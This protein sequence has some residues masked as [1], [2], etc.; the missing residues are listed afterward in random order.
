[1]T[2]PDF[3][4]FQ[5][6]PTGEEITMH[7]PDGLTPQQVQISEG[8]RLLG[9]DEILPRD[10]GPELSGIEAWCASDG[11]W[12]NNFGAGYCGHEPNFTYRTHLS[13]AELRAARGLEPEQS[14]QD[15]LKHEQEVQNDLLGT[16]TPRTDV[17]TQP[18]YQWHAAC[19]DTAPLELTLASIARTL[20]RELTEVTRQRNEARAQIVW[21]FSEDE[22]PS[23]TQGTA[24]EHEMTEPVTA[25]ECTGY[26][27]KIVALKAENAKLLSKHA[28]TKRALDW[29]EKHGIATIGTWRQFAFPRVLLDPVNIGACLTLIEAIDAAIVK[30]AE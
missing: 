27:S 26:I 12:Y 7:N 3:R 28:S 11:E 5:L 2:T 8:W 23:F 14:Y 15:V 18:F 22:I 13:R 25:E 17:A 24:G 30:E 21:C 6:S 29:L 4:Y 9:E 19:Y 20:E 1:M 16:A 10:T